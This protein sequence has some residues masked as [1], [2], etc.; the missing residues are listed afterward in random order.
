[1]C[2]YLSTPPEGVLSACP[3]HRFWIVAAL[4]IHFDK[5]VL[6][7]LLRM[8]T[9][10]RAPASTRRSR[11]RRLCHLGLSSNKNH[12]RFGVIY[13]L[14]SVIHLLSPG[15]TLEQLACAVARWLRR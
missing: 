3:G 15:E 6:V 10:L 9:A 2:I 14:P 13:C 5:G 7:V 12:V 1:M 11:C 4:E 8:E